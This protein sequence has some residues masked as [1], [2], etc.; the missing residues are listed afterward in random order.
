[1]KRQ[2]ASLIIVVVVIAGLIS[3]TASNFLFSSPKNRQEKVPF[4]EP[5]SAD[6]KKPDQKY[7][8]SNSIDPTRIIK[9]GD[10]NNNQP[11]NKQ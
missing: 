5:I 9:I 2:D 6:F 10:N 1:M 8:N 7:F 4:V 3:F 11:F